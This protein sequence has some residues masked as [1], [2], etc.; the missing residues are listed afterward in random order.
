[1][2]GSGLN[3]GSTDVAHIHLIAILEY[4]QTHNKSCAV[5]FVDISA[6]F[7]SM[8]REIVFSNWESDQQFIDVCE[9]HG[10]DRNIALMFLQFLEDNPLFQSAIR[11]K[12]KD[13]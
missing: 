10:V 11:H 2:Y 5:L 4:A 3:K 9:Q 6:A 12:H 8:S 7:A 1:M 13:I